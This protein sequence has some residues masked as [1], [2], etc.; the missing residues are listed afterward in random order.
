MYNIMSRI[1]TVYT[2]W[3]LNWV[4]FVF[5]DIQAFIYD[6][7]VLEYY[8]GRDDKCKLIV[9]G[10]WYATTGYAIGMPQD[11]PWLEKINSVLLHMQDTG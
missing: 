1:C 11:S 4:T 8:V 9:V 10:D 6:A 7:T 3:N 2:Y 5:R